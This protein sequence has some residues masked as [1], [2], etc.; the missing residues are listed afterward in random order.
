MC[1]IRYPHYF[2]ILNLDIDSDKFLAI[3]LL[4]LDIFDIE[5]P[6]SLIEEILADIVDA[7]SATV[8]IDFDKLDIVL[9]ISTID[10]A[11]ELNISL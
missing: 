7:E 6:L 3:S 8:D 9:E 1:L 11:A 5:L 2:Y 4:L 10:D